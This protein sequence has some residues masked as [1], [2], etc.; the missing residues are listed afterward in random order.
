MT[1]Q[2]ACRVAREAGAAELWLTHFGPAV[3][4]PAEYAEELRGIFPGT[5]IDEDGPSR[6][7]SFGKGRPGASGGAPPDGPDLTEGAAAWRGAPPSPPS[8]GRFARAPGP[9]PP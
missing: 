3:G 7:L 6:E 4:D 2:E 8:P 1:M 5:V 9:A